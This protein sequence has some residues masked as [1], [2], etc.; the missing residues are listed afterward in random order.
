MP[1]KMKNALKF[2]ALLLIVVFVVAS[3]SGMQTETPKQTY[4]KATMT[5]NGLL[6][7]YISD[8][9]AA[10]PEIRDK[11]TAEI[12]PLFE[13]A[14]LALKAWGAAIKG[15]GPAYTEQQSYL[16]LK[17]KLLDMLLAELTD[18]EK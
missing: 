3:C 5:F 7:D 18:Y 15:E 11:W 1:K 10:P 13:T 17:N 9:K 4:L 8:K 12:D 16:E 14:S 6:A 2:T